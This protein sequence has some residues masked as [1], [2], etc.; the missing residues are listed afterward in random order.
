MFSNANTRYSNFEYHQHAAC[1]LT[2][3]TLSLMCYIL[4]GFMKQRRKE[5]WQPGFDGE[6]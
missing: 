1:I 4:P 2:V 6:E 5:R 3:I